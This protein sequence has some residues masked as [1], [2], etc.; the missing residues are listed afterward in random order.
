MLNAI[1]FGASSGIGCS[2]TK[3]LIKDDYKVVLVAR[4]RERLESISSKYPENTIVKVL[5][6]QNISETEK[7][8]D[9]IINE[10]K[11]VHLIIHTS[12]I[13]H[14]NK[15][16]D[17]NKEYETIKTNVLAATRI[18]DLAFNI[19]KKQRFGHL[20]SIS[21][22]GALR[23]NKEAPA[24][25]ATKSYQANYLES[26]YFK[27]KE[28]E[29]KKVFITD[30]RPGFIDTNMAKGDGIFWM[31]SVEKAS[32]QIYNAIKKKKRRVYVTKRWYLLSWVVKI[33]PSWLLKKL[34]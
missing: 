9:E 25:S 2:L 31:A 13:G 33:V 19:F 30:V 8:F 26:L 29:G 5:D 28:V 22:F 16:L 7:V 11:E 23:G 4:R 14:I 1:V 21:S 20:V 27:A 32:K 6:V 10:I 15:E 34:M 17:W 12:G 18:Y 3:L 24:Y